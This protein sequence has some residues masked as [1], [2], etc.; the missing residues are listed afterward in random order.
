MNCCE[1]TLILLGTL[2]AL[3]AA[4]PAR[5]QVAPQGSH[6]AGRPSDTGFA[7]LVN[8]SGGYNTSIPLDLIPAKRDLPVQ[9]QVS[10]GGRAV[11]AAGM[12]W[13]VS[14]SYILRDTTYAHRLPGY[15][16]S[17]GAG[18]SPPLGTERLTLMLDGRSTLL[19]RKGNQ[20]T[21]TV[22]VPVHDGPQIEVHED[23][24]N[25]A[26]VM[27]DGAGRTYVFANT[28]PVGPAGQPP[29]G[30]VPLLGGKLYTLASITAP[31][32]KVIVEY[33]NITFQLP[34]GGTG[35]EIDLHSVSYNSP[36][37]D[38]D[39]FKNRIVL[40]YNTP[41]AVPLAM[42]MIGDGILV[43]MSTL[44]SID[45][46]AFEACASDTTDV[47]LRRH[48]FNY[49]SDPDTGL[50]Q[51]RS[52]DLAGRQGTPEGNK[53]ISLGSFTYG[54]ASSAVSGT[55]RRAVFY[56]QSDTVAMPP[57]NDVDP[58]ASLGMTLHTSDGTANTWHELVD[59]TGDGRPDLI[60]RNGN[61]M[62]LAVNRPVD[63][64]GRTTFDTPIVM[65]A[66]SS[67]A[68]LASPDKPIERET[69][70]GFASAI[71]PEVDERHGTDESVYRQIID[72]N[73]DGRLDVIDAH[74]TPG[75]WVFYLNTPG[76]D[77]SQIV[78]LRRP[79]D[80]TPLLTQ[81]VN[82]GHG[83]D[84]NYLP[85]SRRHTGVESV[86]DICF[87]WD[88]TI[89][90]HDWVRMAPTDPQLNPG[91][92]DY[93]NT[94]VVE[95]TYIEWE[96]RD[97][98]GDG[99]VDV[100]F[101]HT[102]PVEN[103]II[104]KPGFTG[105]ANQQARG[106][107][108]HTVLLDPSNT[109]EAVVNVIGP[110]LTG[111]ET[112]ASAYPFSAP[113]QIEGPRSVVLRQ[114]QAPVDPGD[115]LPPPG[116]TVSA[117]PTRSCGVALWAEPKPEGPIVSLDFLDVAT[118]YCA[119]AE[120]NGDGLVDRIEGQTAFLQGGNGSFGATAITLPS[121]AQGYTD[122]HRTACCN[123]PNA[124]C[125]IRIPC[126]D[127]HECLNPPKICNCE[128]VNGQCTNLRGICL[129]PPD[130]GPTAIDFHIDQTFGLKDINGDGVLDYLNHF[131]DPLTR[132]YLSEVR[133][134]TG[135][136]F[137]RGITVSL[138][139]QDF[140][141]SQ[142]DVFCAGG[143]A[144]MV[145]G[146]YDIDGDGTAE[147][148]FVD[149]SVYAL[150]GDS[151]A[152]DA[153]RLT[154]ID[155]GHGAITKITYTS[156]KDD[157]S[158]PHAVPFPEIVVA[159]VE[160][161]TAS[162][163]ARVLSAAVRHA[164][165]NPQ[166]VFDPLQLK[167]QFSGY[168]RTVEMQL[169]DN[170]G[171]M[172]TITDTSG[173]APFLGLANATGRFL[174]NSIVGRPVDV[175][176]LSGDVG[177]DPWAGLGVS[178]PHDSRAIA[179][180]HYEYSGKLFEEPRGT[181]PGFCGELVE[182]YDYARSLRDGSP[183][184]PCVSH[185]FVF[186]N[187]RTSWRGAAPPAASAAN[188]TSQVQITDVDDFGNVLDAS[189]SGDGD[190]S[191]RI[192]VTYAAPS[193]APG[194][195]APRV[196]GAIKERTVMVDGAFAAQS[197]EQW[198]YDNDPPDHPAGTVSNG[199]VTA[200]TAFRVRGDSAIALGADRTEVLWR[201]TAGG[202]PTGV[203]SV[204]TST[205]EGEDGHITGIRKVLLLDYDAFNLAPSTQQVVTVGL[206]GA[207]AIPTMTTHIDV[208]PF[209]LM[210]RS[211]TDPNG[212]VHGLRFDGLDRVTLTTI[213]LPGR[214]EGA[215]SSMSYLGFAK[216]D[217]APQS[218]VRKVF[219]DPVA[220][221]QVA[222]AAGRTSTTFLDALGR[223][224]SVAIELG[225]GYQ[226][227]VI[228]AGQRTYDGLGRVIYE[229]DPYPSTQSPAYA[230]L[231]YF[232]DDGT[233][234]CVV[235]A[236]L[237][238]FSRVI[239]RSTDESQQIYP[240]C[241]TRSFASHR[242]IVA[243]QS[244]DSLLDGSPQAGVIETTTRSASGLTLSHS[245][246]RGGTALEYAEYGYDSLGRLRTMT[247]YRDPA[248]RG[249]AVITSWLLDSFGLVLQL[250]EPGTARRT[251]T[252]D[253]WGELVDE[254]W[255]DG[256]A[257][258]HLSSRYDALGRIV[259][260][261][262]S[263]D[264]TNPNVDPDTVNDYSYDTAV[265]V[266]GTTTLN[267]TYVLG[268][269]AQAVSPTQ[270]VVFS[271]DG[272]GNI[273]AK[274]FSDGQLYV[275]QQHYH[276]DGS[277]ASLDLFLPDHTV[278]D[279]G[280]ELGFTSVDEQVTYGYD[281]AGR[282]T[283][284]SYTDCNASNDISSGCTDTRD[285]FRST[286]IDVLG[287]LREAQYGNTS[288][289]AAYAEAGRRLLTD[290]TL[291]ATVNG[292]THSRKISFPTASGTTFDPIGRERERTEIR[293]GD[294]THAI[295]FSNVYDALGRLETHKRQ[296]ASSGD[297]EV[298]YDF[299]YD[300][301]GNATEL[302][303]S[304]EN[305][306]QNA[307]LTYPD[308]GDLDRICRIRY[309][310]DRNTAC[311]VQHDAAGN[312]TQMP[313]GSGGLR[314]IS[315]L[316]GGAVRSVSDDAGNQAQYKYGAFGEVTQL[317]VDSPA[318]GSTRHDR[319]YGSMIDV[320]DELVDGVPQPVTTR[321]IALPGGAFAT[322]HG[323]TSTWI[324]GFGEE[325]G[326]RFF[327]DQ[328][329]NFVQDVAY[330]PYGALLPSIQTP[331][332]QRT[333]TYSNTQWNG[334][335]TL[336]KLGI[337]QLGARLYDPI[338]GRFLGRDPLLTPRTS[339][340]SNPY[341]FA[342]NDPV[343]LFD[344]T[345]LDS[346]GNWG[347]PEELNCQES[348]T[349]FNANSSSVYFAEGQ[350]AGVTASP[351]QIQS[352]LEN[353]LGRSLNSFETGLVY[354]APQDGIIGVTLYKIRGT[355]WAYHVMHRERGTGAPVNTP[356]GADALFTL[357][358]KPIIYPH[359]QYKMEN[360]RMEPLFDP[361]G[362]AGAALAGPVKAAVRITAGRLAARAFG[363]EL[364][365][366]ESLGISEATEASLTSTFS[367]GGGGVAKI[368][369]DEAAAAATRNGIDMRMFDL[370]YEPG[371]HFGFISQTGSGALWRSANGRIVLTLQDAGLSSERAAVETISH[372]LNHV[373]GI[374][375]TGSP[376][377]E[378]AAERAAEAASRFF[379]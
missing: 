117:T 86:R 234:D 47:I 268:R 46:H 210:A 91:C 255:N 50:P 278:D 189:T 342:E 79:V 297:V 218:I 92:A 157:A 282:V 244:A 280:S 28:G 144:D 4:S 188:V 103:R 142:Q 349:F 235:R 236:P 345:G 367:R 330:Q 116:P 361:M 272:F 179:A 251:R 289:S 166:M 176:V 96:L 221:D 339:A 169:N 110:L 217:T 284:V 228:V 12:G 15:D 19:M 147:M 239:A 71:N 138:S 54:A 273:A 41:A 44:R 137:T 197:L 146:L 326:V 198:Q 125:Q 247:R 362:L 82:R 51:L 49:G 149:G 230:T 317:E 227:Q 328:A 32:N 25:G 238:A 271:Y 259:H 344:P 77:P 266:T 258:R 343:N 203:P 74:E 114:P 305:T 292:H 170:G 69:L 83:F 182:P 164:F 193:Q 369:L 13:D 168:R 97:I 196:L 102:L 303:N 172:M 73:G 354:S 323:V 352:H 375:A 70:D 165:G 161:D 22:W 78:W 279:R 112:A 242:E 209:T 24:R 26:M 171:G 173:L 55:A 14:I 18:G 355:P 58:T 371:P 111:S 100:M 252:Y 225:A 335:D 348:V 109:I 261:E 122:R 11:G 333:S 192:L 162:S 243:T 309:G 205:R 80:V 66:A 180:T 181:A 379:R 119:F 281:S 298:D 62:M 21:S 214:T 338:I 38:A 175:T 174:A 350:F 337:T 216:D 253:S 195:N 160:I 300:A 334:G 356:V 219:T 285:L 240:T 43:R 245:S 126:D 130:P 287:R 363:A 314:T 329:G 39:C 301:L 75:Q 208:E 199:F 185:G 135:T 81:L 265:S 148:V 17:L 324:F 274:A 152:R 262:E 68:V 186:T 322:R 283:S 108:S 56:T 351:L 57:T 107:D 307:V 48:V 246:S 90:P 212:T 23:T 153:G 316:A 129:G 154:S 158:T 332:E 229:A 65:P 211:V 124:D 132:S 45:M 30:H 327:T 99:Y 67:G 178:V 241:F 72:V 118:Q 85:L 94:Q 27:Y 105:V 224:A 128:K 184:Q 202:V 312:I 167:W 150:S 299:S 204:V 353:A 2:A 359:V 291:S 270:S 84:G 64:S 295:T 156:A 29:L 365:T 191:Q 87:R 88:T 206:P 311:N 61:S 120:V 260:R 5:A 36:T 220:I 6:Q 233:A 34:G 104:Q 33:L 320:R 183:F 31:G 263:T 318:A 40:D 194:S 37:S 115:P 277:L 254:Q 123:D 372:E 136:D 8:S 249:G 331:S 7:G 310:F 286:T 306:F 134:G 89:S 9:V 35:L 121:Y 98:N 63:M 248:N 20:Q 10:Y 131:Y 201:V 151:K 325:R 16:A 141:V 139:G 257:V 296:P 374:F 207:P 264:G 319:H 60:Y 187:K 52:V 127:A 232:K 290:W 95:F 294:T 113:I 358:G 163:P 373:R 145:G 336:Q 360:G 321:T 364:A 140:S 341:A 370:A 368:T 93:A 215:L 288:Y 42:T 376:S 237:A 378:A 59:I 190:P 302:F 377:E 200:H 213:T 293:D 76:S 106:F 269:L 315:Y 340:T 231:R 256:T 159:S 143:K 276:G 250:D 155:N 275:E 101:N 346:R 313:T 366:S 222:T 3:V 226:N 267:P 53:V 347:C 308:S 223:E 304:S 177:N 357:E 133:L 1:R